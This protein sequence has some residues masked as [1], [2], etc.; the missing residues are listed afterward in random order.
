VA[1]KPPASHDFYVPASD[2]NGNSE[3]IRIRMDPEL[4]GWLRSI[5]E[6]GNH[7]YRTF[8]EMLRHGIKC[9]AGYLSN[10]GEVSG[11]FQARVQALHRLRRDMSASM[12]YDRIFDQLSETIGTLRTEGK[13]ALA[14]DLI[15]DMREQV[16]AMPDDDRWSRHYQRRFRNLFPPEKKRGK[17]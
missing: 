17:G 1:E 7:D 4:V 16:E 8:N 14:K 3:T 10:I 5:Y 6:K 9:H 2:A 12:Q 13:N 11:K 15:R